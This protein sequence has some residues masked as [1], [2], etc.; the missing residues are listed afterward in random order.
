KMVR[1]SITPPAKPPRPMDWSNPYAYQ[2]KAGQLMSQAFPAATLFSGAASTVA[3]AGQY[4]MADN[5]KQRRDALDDAF[6]ASR[7]VV[8][9]DP[10]TL[11]LH[12]YLFKQLGADVDAKKH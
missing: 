6:N 5:T 11:A 1:S 4:A 7:Q 9:T 12:K 8:P 10:L 2:A 3:S